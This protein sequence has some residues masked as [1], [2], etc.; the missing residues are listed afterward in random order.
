MTRDALVNKIRAHIRDRGGVNAGFGWYV[1]ISSDPKRRLF[2]DHNVDKQ[3]GK[4][5][6]RKADSN[7]I[8]RSA[9]RYLLQMGCE[10]GTGGGDKKS[11]YVYAYKIT[12]ST[13]E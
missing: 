1:G 9:E 8:A 12:Q 4:W 11:L 6:W 2:E 5:I 13:V 10:G 3:R 7:A